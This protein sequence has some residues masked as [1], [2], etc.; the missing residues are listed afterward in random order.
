VISRR[1]DLPLRGR[2]FYLDALVVDVFRFI[3][4]GSTSAEPDA[5]EESTSHCKSQWLRAFDE[6]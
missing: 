1:Q 6:A 2:L 5:F 4:R 3:S